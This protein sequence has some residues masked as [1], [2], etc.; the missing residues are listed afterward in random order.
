MWNLMFL[1]CACSSAKFRRLLAVHLHLSYRLFLLAQC[2]GESHWHKA[3]LSWSTRLVLWMQLNRFISSLYNSGL[4]LVVFVALY[5]CML[6]QGYIMIELLVSLHTHWSFFSSPDTPGKSKIN[7]EL[8]MIELLPGF[9]SY[10]FFM[11]SDCWI[12]SESY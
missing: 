7:N 4:R 10:I 8:I 11:E 5:S 1:I 9:T 3:D 12:K 6:Y 2:V